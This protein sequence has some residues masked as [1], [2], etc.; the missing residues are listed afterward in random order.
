M[1]SRMCRRDK[2]DWVGLSREIMRASASKRFQLR[3]NET[4]RLG[5]LLVLPPIIL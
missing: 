4:N 5:V 2:V 1:A 3:G